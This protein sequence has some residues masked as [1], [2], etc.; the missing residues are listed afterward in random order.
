MIND[1][2][3][4]AL[5]GIRVLTALIYGFLS[6]DFGLDGRS[7]IMFMSLLVGL[8]VVTYLAEG[9]SVLLSNRRLHVAAEIRIYGAALAIAVVSVVLSRI[10]DFKPGVLYGFVASAVLLAPITLGRRQQAEIVLVP[11]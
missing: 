5:A 3:P 10:I 8:G 7:V 1:A 11:T 6:P 4:A 9:G 2:V